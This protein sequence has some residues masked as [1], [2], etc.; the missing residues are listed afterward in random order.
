MSRDY[1]HF[2]QTLI[3]LLSPGKVKQKTVENRFWSGLSATN[4]NYEKIS[5]G[6]Y[7][8]KYR[9]NGDT[10]KIYDIIVDIM[11]T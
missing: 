2:S 4:Y 8:W 9:I 10:A 6:D 3:I 11:E 7:T 1:L 5:V